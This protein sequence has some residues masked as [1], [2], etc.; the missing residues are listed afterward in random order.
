MTG[1]LE[2][3]IGND[4]DINGFG[5]IQGTIPAYS[6]KDWGKLQNKFSHNVISWAE[7]WIRDLPNTKQDYERDVRRV[8]SKKET[9]IAVITFDL[10]ICV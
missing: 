7:I 5:L 2:Q 1:Y 10:V 8:S 4:V 6:C 9:F 3:W